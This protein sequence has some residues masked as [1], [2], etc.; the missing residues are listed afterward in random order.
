MYHHSVFVQL[1]RFSVVIDCNSKESFLR[2]KPFF[3]L[4]TTESRANI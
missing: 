4:T 3:V 2:A 1:D